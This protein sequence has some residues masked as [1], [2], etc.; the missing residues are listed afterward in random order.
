MLG[1][2]IFPAVREASKYGRGGRGEVHCYKAGGLVQ[3]ESVAERDFFRLMEWDYT[4]DTF[5]AQPFK[6]PSKLPNGRASH[7]TPDCFAISYKFFQGKSPKYDPTAFEIKT[8]EEL[9]EDWGDLKPKLRAGRSF[10]GESGFRFR[11]L[12]EDRIHAVFL[13]NITFLLRFRGPRFMLRTP[14][15]GLMVDD[16]MRYVKRSN[17]DFTP[18]ELLDR[19]SGVAPREQVIPWIWNLYADYVLQCDLRTP[20]TLDTVS[21]RCGDAGIGFANC[22]FPDSRA[23]WRQP[24]YDWRR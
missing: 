5:V 11:I 2:T 1:K 12:T 15:E 22:G 16:L 9:R 7:Y 20:L 14:A 19:V 8:K 4:V 17:D 23:D 6:I 18:R 24:E 21:W 3:H 10:L 13:T